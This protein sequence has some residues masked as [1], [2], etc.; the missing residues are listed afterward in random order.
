MYETPGLGI[1]STII[2]IILILASVVL[3]VMGSMIILSFLTR[4]QIDV[5]EEIVYN[6]NI[7]IALVLSSFIWTIGRM[8]LESTKPIM[9]DWYNR[10]ASGITFTSVL[11]FTAGILGA[12]LN[13]LI[14]GA[15]I[16]FLSIKILMVINKDINEWEEIKQ[17]NIAVAIVISITVIVVGMFFESIISYIATNI[18]QFLKI[19]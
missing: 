19:K 2:Y 1:I 11:S 3:S 4:R 12:L 9:N 5:K 18:L 10:W 8:C 13:A 17:G 6:Q 7:G 15:I 14:F 16:V